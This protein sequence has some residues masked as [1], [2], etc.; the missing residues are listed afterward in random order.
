M[1]PYCITDSELSL[2]HTVL[3]EFAA[4]ITRHGISSLDTDS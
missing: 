3:E 4:Q 1:P 2:T